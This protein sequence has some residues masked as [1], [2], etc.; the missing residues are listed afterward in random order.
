MSLPDMS[1]VLTAWEQPALIKT[2]T[3]TTVD[4]EPVEAVTGRTQN[5]VIQVADKE[6]LQ[7]DTINWSLEYLMVHSKAGIEMGELIEYKDRDFKVVSRGP[8]QDYGYTEVVAEETKRP[9][10]EVTP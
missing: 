6:D 9:L 10:V 5:C 3:E 8:W 7:L 4:F 2:V 1:D